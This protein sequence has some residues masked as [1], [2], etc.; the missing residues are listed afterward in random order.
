MAGRT[1]K[2]SGIHGNGMPRNTDWMSGQR[3]QWSN[4]RLE[5][6]RK[7]AEIR[8]RHDIYQRSP[9]LQT[10]VEDT[11]IPLNKQILENQPERLA[12][13]PGSRFSTLN[14]QERQQGAQDSRPDRGN[15]MPQEGVQ[16]RN[17]LGE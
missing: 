14:V 8:P 10:K 17:E 4:V 6:L 11:L 15:C 7:V 16:A 13:D 3:D 5:C 9:H 2:E 12:I 1:H